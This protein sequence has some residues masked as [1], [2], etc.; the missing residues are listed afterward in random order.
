MVGVGEGIGVAVSEGKRVAV[1]EGKAVLGGAG[2]A[3]AIRVGVARGESGDVG[4]GV[5]MADAETGAFRVL[6]SQGDF[7]GSLS[8]R[9]DRMLFTST[10]DGDAELYLLNVGSG[11]AERLTISPGAD[12]GAVFVAEPIRP[13]PPS[14]RP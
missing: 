8:A 1:G 12:D 9:G 3:V 5:A 7:N 4:A 11:S 2:S 13:S 10:R 6:T 14:R